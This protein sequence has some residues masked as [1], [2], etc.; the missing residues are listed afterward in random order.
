MF[1]ERIDH[2]GIGVRQQHHVGLVDAF[3][4]GDGRTVD[5]WYDASGTAARV[6]YK[7]HDG[8]TIDFVLASTD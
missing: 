3:P 8:S 2:G 5:L 4:A 6:I 7:A 1:R